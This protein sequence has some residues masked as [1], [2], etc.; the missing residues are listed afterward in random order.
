MRITTT[1]A[2]ATGLTR[3]K[4]PGFIPLTRSRYRLTTLSSRNVEREEER[5]G[6]ERVIFKP[7]DNL[8]FQINLLADL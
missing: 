6:V 8:K 3:K 2:C 5:D 1:L 7:L 4:N